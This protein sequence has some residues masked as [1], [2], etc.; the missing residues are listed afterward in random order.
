MHAEKVGMKNINHN[1]CDLLKAYQIWQVTERSLHGWCS[2]T[3]LTLQQKI[4]IQQMLILLSNTTS[5]IKLLH[6]TEKIIKFN[7]SPCMLSGAP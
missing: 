4:L 3:Q 1:Q 5:E 6:R 2:E 7:T